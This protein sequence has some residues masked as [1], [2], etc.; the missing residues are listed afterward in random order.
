MTTLNQTAPTDPIYEPA[1]FV[2]IRTPL[3]PID[4]LRSWLELPLESPALL[5][6]VEG[7]PVALRDALERDTQAVRE[8]LRAMVGD[9]VVQEAIL[10]GSP[11]LFH[12]IPRWLQ[13]PDSRKGRQAQANLLRYLIRMTTRP[14]PFG[15][16]AG[17]ALGAIGATMD[18]RIGPL[19]QNTKRTRP[20]MQWL[21]Y[22]IRSLEQRPEVIAHLR[23]FTN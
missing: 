5:P 7:H 12:A 4:S 23:F 11:D 13:A 1:G 18:I 8:Q 6:V 3:L 20:D 15:L 14:T 22:L 17:V 10:T 9:P 21:L 16:F 19:A 2:M